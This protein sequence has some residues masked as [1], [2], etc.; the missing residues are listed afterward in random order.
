MH[1]LVDQLTMAFC[2]AT[3]QVEVKH[4]L[5]ACRL[6]C[7]CM[8]CLSVYA[9]LKQV[10]S[11]ASLTCI[12]CC[13]R[14]S[15][16]AA[17]VQPSLEPCSFWCLSKP[18][19]PSLPISEPAIYITHCFQARKELGIYVRPVEETIIDW[20]LTLFQLGLASPV[21]KGC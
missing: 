14:A 13:Q 4:V 11:Q 15:K 10:S 9:G 18:V 21:P 6:L 20:A 16:L 19:L 7:T 1:T 3:R 8:Q 12:L 2:Q 17:C 5:A